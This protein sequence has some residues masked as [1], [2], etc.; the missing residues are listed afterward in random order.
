[1]SWT[2]Q[3][4][5]FSPSITR[6][7]AAPAG[8]ASPSDPGL[9]VSPLVDGAHRRHRVA[10][11]AVP[12][13]VPGSIVDTRRVL[14]LRYNHASQRLQ[15]HSRFNLLV[16]ASGWHVLGASSG[17]CLSRSHYRRPERASRTAEHRR[18]RVRRR[19]RSGCQPNRADWSGRAVSEGGRFRA[20]ST[21]VGFG[22]EPLQ[23]RPR[24]V[25]INTRVRVPALDPKLIVQRFAD[26]LENRFLG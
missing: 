5:N 4:T 20:G 8:R 10:P 14:C 3:A 18:P 21:C 2:R 26:H 15:P 9:H 24:L 7:R 19:G 25:P 17:S 6:S 1:M 12:F 16:S 11:G 23:E 22:V 13:R